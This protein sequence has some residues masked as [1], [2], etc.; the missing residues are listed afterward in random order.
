[1]ESCCPSQ[2]VVSEPSSGDYCHAMHK[3]HKKSLHVKVSVQG[4]NL[5]AL[6]DTGATSSFVHSSTV[7]KLG[8]ESHVRPCHHDVRFGNG[9]IETLRGE[10]TLLVKI[11]GKDLGMNAYV[12]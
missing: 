10:I 12:L 8:L 11:G 4:V 2:I 1:M 6:V 3:P 7:R 9:E 5:M